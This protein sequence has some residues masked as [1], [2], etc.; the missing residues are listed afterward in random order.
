M[1]NTKKNNENKTQYYDKPFLLEGLKEIT[2]QKK[3]KK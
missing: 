3:R 1:K 2:K